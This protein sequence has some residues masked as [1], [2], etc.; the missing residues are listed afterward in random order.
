MPTPMTADELRAFMRA[1]LFCH[2]ATLTAEGA[3]HVAPFICDYDGADFWL[4]IQEGRPQLEHLRRDPRIALS[5]VSAS[6]PIDHV[7]V[8]GRAELLPEDETVSLRLLEKYMP[9]EQARAYHGELRAQ[10]TPTTVRV[11]PSELEA[12]H[13]R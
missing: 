13:Y 2:V 4:M 6:P 9:S 7:L 10:G 1:R 5:I 8:R 12:V 11:R 3:P